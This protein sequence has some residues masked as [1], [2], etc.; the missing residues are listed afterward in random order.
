M[1][2]LGTLKPKRG[3]IQGSKRIGRGRGSG[4]GGTAAKGHKGQKA[5]KSGH[6]RRGFEGGQTPFCLKLP[7]NCSSQAHIEQV[8]S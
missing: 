7:Q 2:V 8:D 5:R 6:I 1:S 3:S 4:K